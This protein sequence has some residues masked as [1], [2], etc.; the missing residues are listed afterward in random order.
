MLS[1]VISYCS[2]CATDSKDVRTVFEI[3]YPDSHSCGVP[4][5]VTLSVCL[6]TCWCACQHIDN[7]WT[8][9]C[10]VCYW[11]IFWKLL[12]C[13]SFHVDKA[14]VIY[15]CCV[16]AVC[17]CLLKLCTVASCVILP[18]LLVCREQNVCQ[19]ESWVL[20]WALVF[21]LCI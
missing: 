17:I 15:R 4:V 12:S 3:T 7:Y 18:L 6:L 11:E 14:V 16:S 1:F 9:L 20:K 10:E 13:F 21:I 5:T 2:L 8:V 19:R